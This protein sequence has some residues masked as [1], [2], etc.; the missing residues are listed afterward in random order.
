[1]LKDPV[2]A[3]V[4][5]SS[6]SKIKNI[7]FLTKIDER[8]YEIDDVYICLKKSFPIAE[9]KLVLDFDEE[10]KDT[11]VLSQTQ[12]SNLA[13]MVANDTKDTLK[14]EV[15]S[16]ARYFLFNVKI[17]TKVNTLILIEIIKLFHTLFHKKRIIKIRIITHDCKHCII[18][19][20]KCDRIIDINTLT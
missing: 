6:D 8:T 4:M 5:F 18:T 20:D 19:R 9:T 15:L 2:K 1:M 16:P 12:L 13:Q 17:P 11:L 10:G 7:S 3:Y 14:I